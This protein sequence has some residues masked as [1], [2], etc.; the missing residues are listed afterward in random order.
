[1]AAE[2]AVA[3]VLMVQELLVQETVVVATEVLLHQVHLVLQIEAAAAVAVE[4]G[5][6]AQQQTLVDRVVLAS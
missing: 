4:A 6:V 3:S 1:M 5:L 2:A